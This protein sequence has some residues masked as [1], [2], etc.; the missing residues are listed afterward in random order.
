MSDHRPAVVEIRQENRRTLALKVT[1]EGLV[2]LIPLD[3]DPDDSKVRSFIEQGLARLP[4]PQ[5]LSE[6]EQ[7]TE[8]QLRQL[9]ATWCQKLGVG[10]RQVQVRPLLRKWASI[11]TAGDLTLALDLLQL[12]RELI[13]YVICHELL[14]LRVPT[15]SRGFQAMLRAWIPDWEERQLR[16]AAWAVHLGSATV[17]ARHSPESH[18]T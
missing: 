11:S 16:L 2:A 1:P 18:S 3:L 9:V 4:K 10:V 17:R 14:H 7:C 8:P 15:H 5:P 13:E 12:P 6:H